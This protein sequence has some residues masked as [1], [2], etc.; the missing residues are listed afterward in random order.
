MLPAVS[1]GGGGIFNDFKYL[2]MTAS[3]SADGAW[4]DYTHM[5][6][7]LTHLLGIL[8]EPQQ[9]MAVTPLEAGSFCSHHHHRRS[10]ISSSLIWSAKQ[11][12]TCGLFGCPNWLRH[13]KI[14]KQIVG[15]ASQAEFPL[16]RACN[17]PVSYLICVIN[18]GKARQG[19]FAFG[20]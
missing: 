12:H 9:S 13:R 18:I 2:A 1:S 16:K 3:A 4:T 19:A 10:S 14:T 17:D 20:E 15:P 6:M 8:G 5:W 7:M 11:G